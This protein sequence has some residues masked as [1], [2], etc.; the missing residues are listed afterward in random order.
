MIIHNFKVAIRNLMKYKLQT[1]IS[2][3]SI[4]IGI[5]T[6][7]F[8]HSIL[9]NIQLPSIYY[10]PFHDRA[11]R[12]DFKL[13]SDDQKGLHNTNGQDILLSTQIIRAVKCNDP[14]NSA[15][16]IA[17]ASSGLFSYKV[18][19]LLP[20][21]TRRKGELTSEV[22]DPESLSYAGFRSAITGKKIESL[23]AGQAIISENLAKKFFHNKNPIGAVQTQTNNSQHIPVTIV[24][25][26]K[27]ISA[28]NEPLNYDALYCCLNDHIEDLEMFFDSGYSMNVV[29]K[30]G[31]KE[32][33]LMN[34]L[35][36]RLKP[37]GLKAELSKA[38]DEKKVNTYLAAEGL[39]YIISSLIL[40]ASII[41][42]LRIQ[43]QL[44]RIRR[45]ELALRIVN[46]ARILEL[47]CMLVIEVAIPILL[48][49]ILSLWLGYL[50]KDFIDKLID[51]LPELRNFFIH[52]LW[53]YSLIVGGALLILCSLIAWITLWHLRRAGQGLAANM[54][55]SRRH[56][57]RNVML[58]TQ[59]TISII[60]VCCTFIVIKG[61]DCILKANNIPENDYF[62]KEWLALRPDEAERPQIL[63]EEIKRLPDLDKMVMFC[64]AYA[65][66]NEV[67][68]NP[69]ILEKL[70]SPY[71]NFF[72]TYLMNNPDILSFYGMDVEW[73]NRDVDRN[74]CVLI[75]ENLYRQLSEFGLLNKNTLTL[76]PLIH[77]DE[78]TLPI[79]GIIKKIPYDTANQSIVAISPH[80]SMAYILVPKP[81]RSKAFT[82]S[83]EETIERLEPENLNK[84]VINF[85]LSVNQK[86]VMCETFRTG[87]WILGSVSLII[88][89]MTIFST[90]TLDTRARRKEVA[91]R[92]VNGAKSKDIYL[93]FGRVYLILI[94]IAVFFA[95]PIC[96]IFNRIVDT[97]VK[98][99]LPDATLSPVGP[100]ILGIAIVTLLILLIVGWQIHRVM[101]VDPAKIIAKE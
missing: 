71:S 47:F 36:E 91:I 84:M 16:Q 79:A 99:A 95:I 94:A 39:V 46:G 51:S 14:I 96:V 76:M 97:M 87:S 17:I 3:V 80:L 32:Q 25:V 5:V 9:N 19:F 28:A 21:S 11:Y 77:S 18:D 23:K 100:I 66:I 52:D 69:E 1:L 54:R 70:H 29:L 45:R 8:A 15:E 67:Y 38:L 6:L 72:R 56:L 62:Y 35:D 83:V 92:K 40:V 7:S 53:P 86:V 63:L 78:I 30:E 50:L 22:I 26:Y 42:F 48:S 59:I 93:M 68:E 4:A 89:I 82:K 49:V 75:S 61:S 88:C 85:R 34:E 90:I 10:Q 2:V 33:Q 43:T 44:F 98:D 101:Q 74:E 81:G 41:G 55:R 60:F 65:R 57:F 20:D 31:Y 58:G 37:L 13:I 27:P 64:A 24:D 12:V 73:F